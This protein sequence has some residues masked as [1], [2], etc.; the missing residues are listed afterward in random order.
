ML[1]EEI[2]NNS[3]TSAVLTGYNQK[4]SFLLPVIELVRDNTRILTWIMVFG[5]KCIYYNIA[6]YSTTSIFSW[7]ECCSGQ[8]KCSDIGIIIVSDCKTQTISQCIPITDMWSICKCTANSSTY[9]STLTCLMAPQLLTRH[10]L[11]SNEA[12][13]TP[14]SLGDQVIIHM[15][16]SHNMGIAV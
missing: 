4:A 10:K 7:A 9:H 6:W 14:C 11:P 5:D 1:L 8:S 3:N 16:G 12:S 2:A 13:S 15:M